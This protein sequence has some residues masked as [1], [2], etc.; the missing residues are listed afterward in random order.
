MRCL[1]TI[2][3]GKST[4]QL[5]TVL[6]RQS[7]SSLT[8]VTKPPRLH[9][10]WYNSTARPVAG[11]GLTRPVSVCAHFRGLWECADFSSNTSRLG[12]FWVLTIH[13]M[14]IASLSVG[15]EIVRAVSFT[16]CRTSAHSWPMYISVPIAV[17]FLARL[18]SSSMSE[19]RLAILKGSHPPV[20]ARPPRLEFTSDLPPVRTSCAHDHSAQ[21]EKLIVQLHKS[22]HS[23]HHDLI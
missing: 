6:L 8:V 18:S 16:L 19:S 22:S 5:R 3:L 15:C 10:P 7:R 4:R 9:V 11:R 2:P 12:P 17:P 23:A 20:P 13:I 1:V 14:F 21:A